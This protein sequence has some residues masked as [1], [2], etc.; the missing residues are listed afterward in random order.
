MGVFMNP[1]SSSLMRADAGVPGYGLR[2]GSSEGSVADFGVLRGCND[3]R[4]AVVDMLLTDTL[5]GLVVLV[6]MVSEI[7][8]E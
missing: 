5:V 4:T 6:A 7:T 8:N 2:V 3:G 1:P